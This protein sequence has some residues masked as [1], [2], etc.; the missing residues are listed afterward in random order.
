MYLDPAPCL[1]E[2]INIIF[3]LADHFGHSHPT[4]HVVCH[5][6]LLTIDADR[7][8]IKR[9]ISDRGF[10]SVVHRIEISRHEFRC[11]LLNGTFL[12]GSSVLSQRTHA[13]MSVELNTACA[14]SYIVGRA[15]AVAC[16]PRE[17]D[18]DLRFGPESR[19]CSVNA[20]QPFGWNEINV[21]FHL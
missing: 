20:W 11:K 16:S 2:R 18:S 12:N 7:Q 5:F 9:H 17:H 21:L 19:R 14:D 15:G 6:F 1:G 10:V 8:A 3:Q 4:T 13:R